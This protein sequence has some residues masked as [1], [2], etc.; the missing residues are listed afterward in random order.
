MRCQGV[1]LG[2][3]YKLGLLLLFNF[4]L[5]RPLEV[6]D[7][8]PSIEFMYNIAFD[9]V[10]AIDGQLKGHRPRGRLGVHHYRELGARLKYR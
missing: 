8:G 6:S 3:V 1:A 4:I 10:G 5:Q 9:H 7:L 2:E